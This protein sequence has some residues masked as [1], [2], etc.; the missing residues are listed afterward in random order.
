[1]LFGQN[2]EPCDSA[3]PLA[4]HQVVEVEQNGE[5][6]IA[7]FG[8]DRDGDQVSSFLQ[9]SFVFIFQFLKFLPWESIDLI[10][11]GNNHFSSR[12]WDSVS[13]FASIRQTRL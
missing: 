10:D 9:L 11:K 8:L 6:V 5:V 2:F 4:L 7:L 1:M 3:A 13:S 12:N